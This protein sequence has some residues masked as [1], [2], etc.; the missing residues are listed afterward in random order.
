MTPETLWQRYAAIW[1]LPRD[2]RMP[3]LV[4]CVA[5]DVTYCDPS[6]AIQGRDA[7]SDYMGGFQANVPEGR[8]AITAVLSH[9]GRMLAHWTLVGAGGTALQSGASFALVTED[10]R[11]HSISG[12]FPLA[13]SR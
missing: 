12:F 6:R 2:A 1:S 4:A 8:F 3:E 5:D 9:H 11:L 10:G 13:G 7:L